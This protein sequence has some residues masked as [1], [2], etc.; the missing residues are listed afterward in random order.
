MKLPALVR[1]LPLQEYCT[2]D[3]VKLGAILLTTFLAF[4]DKNWVNPNP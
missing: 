1:K 2:A 4:I 3:E